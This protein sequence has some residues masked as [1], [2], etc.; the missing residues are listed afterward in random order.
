MD[1]FKS[2]EVELAPDIQGL[3]IETDRFSLTVAPQLGGKITSLINKKTN[4]K[5]TISNAN[6]N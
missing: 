6:K 5:D 1:K 2:K 3:K 4:I